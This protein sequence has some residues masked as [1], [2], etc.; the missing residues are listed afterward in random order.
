MDAKKDVEK[1][2][3]D[4]EKHLGNEKMSSVNVKLRCGI[5]SIY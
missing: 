3:K 2:N 4:W 1:Y 5:I